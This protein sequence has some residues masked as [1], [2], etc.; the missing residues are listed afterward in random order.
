MLKRITIILLTFIAGAL[1]SLIM[2]YV[3]QD[4]WSNLFT[5][6]RLIATA[7]S[8]L[9][10]LLFVAFLETERALSWNWR[11][12]R[13]WYLRELL[14]NPELRHWESDFARLEI[15]QGKRARISSAEVLAEGNRKDMIEALRELIKDRDEKKS[16]ALVLG[17]PGSGKTTG[18]ERLTLDLARAAKRRLGIGCKMPVLVRFGNF[19][20]GRL[21]GHIAQTI[22]H[23]TKRSS[24]KILSK[25]IEMLLE[26]GQVV[27]LCDALDEALGT[28]RDLVIAELK[29]LLTSQAYQNVPIIITSRTREDPGEALKGLT[30]FEIQD[31]NDEAVN[32]FVHAYKRSEHNEAEI[33]QRLHAHRLLE[34]GGLGRNPFWLR[35]IVAS[36]AFE[37]NKGQILNTAVDTLL[38]REWDE[39]PHVERSWQ[40][41]LP[42]DEQLEETKRS[43]AF[44]GYWM[45]VGSLVA[46]E[47]EGVLTTFEK[48]WLALRQQA[49][50]R[51]LRPQD[52]L[53]LGRDAQILVYEPELVRFRHRLLQEFMAAW[54]LMLDKSLLEQD[55]DRISELAE[56][57]ETLFL[58]GG[59]LATNRSLEA[60]SDFMEPV[61]GDGTNDQRLFAA[62]GLLRSVENPPAELANR[63]TTKFM[64]SLDE[65]LTPGQ[66][67]AV[68][69]LGRILGGEATK[70][71]RAIFNNPE[72]RIKTKGAA[73][74]CALRSKQANEILL[75]AIR[76]EKERKITTEILVTV[77]EEAVDA[78]INALKDSSQWVREHAAE[79]LG[80]IASTQA[81]EP[82][83]AVLKDSERWVR[84]HAAQA[85]GKIG[86]PRAVDPLIA[87]LKDSD[88]WVR[89]YTAEALGEIADRRAVA[90]LIAALNDSK[91]WVRAYAAAALGEV[92]DINA[93]DPLIVALNDSAWV[94]GHAE[95]ALAKIGNRAIGTLIVTLKDSNGDVR[96]RAASALAKIGNES[97]E[98]LLVALTDPDRE[99]RRS[100]AEAL[101]E[102]GNPRVIDAL[103]AA[104]RD[105]DKWVH[106]HAAEAL[107]KMG[108]PSAVEPLIA[109]LKDLVIDIR[110]YAAGALTKCGSMA[111]EAL[112]D[113]LNDS[114]KDVCERAAK[115]LG[116]IG[117]SRAIEPLVTALTD[118]SKWVRLHAAE[119]LRKMDDSRAIEPLITAL[120]DSDKYVRQRAAEVLGKIGDSSAVEPLITALA[121]SDNWVR[122]RAAEALA[123]MGESRAIDPLI[124]MLHEYSDQHLRWCAAHALGEIDDP[125]V[126]LALKTVVWNEYYNRFRSGTASNAALDAIEKIRQRT[127]KRPKGV[128]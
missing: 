96:R 48:G 120:A 77:G 86:D 104:L 4:V 28:R 1:G 95:S 14:Q 72:R 21:I 58:L 35:L 52:V 67:F 8:I 117:D 46:I 124:T 33:T 75:K 60:Y 6:E 103:I 15:V 11:W 84:W 50:V 114:D 108:N 70:I 121:D 122:L 125:Q 22:R 2:A 53:G 12:H 5:L 97:V 40:R 41:V 37:G 26:H 27:L 62:I 42:R 64:E 119:A 59:L 47:Q 123:K 109:A 73:L 29:N 80:K 19:Q 74:L 55:I 110:S 23:G 85:L 24:G 90:P 16:R 101:G 116:E 113:V 3:Q 30:A 10:M 71:F 32:A 100:A 88:E 118:S 36:G 49:G 13:F 7:V 61:L 106:L 83:I 79:A 9:L 112:I 44:L 51:G 105:S 65:K 126:L 38:A 91:E 68:Q 99:V 25:G 34:A 102:I 39:K 94:S 17:E 92:G 63:V 82:L 78:L 66:V 111:V 20:D 43:L 107:G 18:L 127:A 45:S 54:M 56:W 87:A 128:T 57:W 93:I 81:V 98:P 89:R 115:V 69:E 76:D 31:L